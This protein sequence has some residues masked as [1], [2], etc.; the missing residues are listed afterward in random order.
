MTTKP[1]IL[2]VENE[3]GTAKLLR[4][5]LEGA[6]YAT[7]YTSHGRAGIEMAA[8]EQPNLIIL[9]VHLPEMTGWDVIRGLNAQGLSHLPVMVMSADI[10]AEQD[11]EAFSI[12]AYMHKPFVP[13]ELLATIKR[14][15]RP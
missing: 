3:P 5:L 7:I 9:D 6:G 14:C 11:A 13:D 2:L 15:V 12:C 10:T 8:Q 1:L 4:L